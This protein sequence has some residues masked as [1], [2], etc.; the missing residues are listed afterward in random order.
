MALLAIVSAQQLYSSVK[1]TRQT[2]RLLPSTFNNEKLADLENDLDK[3]GLSNTEE[4]YWNTDIENPDTDGDGFKD[5]EEAIS[6]HNPLVAGPKDFQDIRKNLSEKT[7]NLVFSGLLAG[8]LL[9]NSP[10]YQSALDQISLSVV[11]D[12]YDS[13]PAIPDVPIIST[14]ASMDNQKVYLEYLASVIK[15]DLYDF[16][17]FPFLTAERVPT[18]DSSLRIAGQLG[19]AYNALAT[20]AVP[21]NWKD[22][23]L[24]VLDILDRLRVNHLHLADYEKDPLKALLAA[25]EITYIFETEARTL[26]KQVNERVQELNIPVSDNFFTV[27]KLL[28]K[29]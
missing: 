10:A 27:M 16:N 3:D 9:P 26:M 13:Q 12:F 25:K 17:F 21:K 28:Y 18:R 22:A 1:A 6:G 4:A 19:K 7:S 2:A 29:Y 14:D 11:H 23:H 5:G 24:Q 15:N 20:V 8:D